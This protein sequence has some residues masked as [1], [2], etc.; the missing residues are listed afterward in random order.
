MGGSSPEREISLLSG[1]AVLN[2]LSDI[3]IDAHKFDSK[4]DSL[5]DLIEHKYAR[6]FLVTHGDFGEDGVLQGF[7]ELCKI[8]YTGSGVLSSAIA[9][10]K[11]R[12][13]LIW[14]ASKIPIPKNQ[15]LRHN[16]YQ[17]RGFKLELD[18]PVIVKPSCGGSTLGLSKVY[19]L[20]DLSR[21]LDL[22]F[23][24]DNGGGILVEELIIGDEYT[25]V[26]F[27]DKVYPI[28]KIEAENNNYDYEN[29]YFTDTTRYICPYDLEDLQVIIEEYARIGYNVVG[30]RGVARL[31]FMIDV[32]KNIY[33]LEINTLPGMTGHSLVPMAFQAVGYNFRELC[34]QM[35]D[36]ARVGY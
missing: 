11:Y 20:E 26:V 7:L 9:Y 35:L 16:D 18:L 21:A 13:Q 36:D 12:T 17:Q 27:N 19:A 14:G 3:G 28:I 4:L 31:D 2:A 5:N 29:K 24:V 23:S 25:I 32:N 22:A 10:D 34:L 30:A 15:Y 8:P 33:F 6:A 1:E